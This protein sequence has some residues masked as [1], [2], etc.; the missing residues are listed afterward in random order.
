[1]IAAIYARKSTDQNLPDAEKPV[2]RQVDH[3]TAY[4]TRKGWTVAED[5]V[6]ADDAISG[7]LFGAQRPGLYRLLNA[8]KP[9]PP[10][11]V[12]VVMDQSRL[13][14]EQDEVPVACAGSRR[15]GSAS[16]ATS[17]T[18]RSSA[19]P[20]SRSFR[21]PRSRSWMRWPASKAGSAP[22]TRW[23]GRRVRGTSRAASCTG[24]RNVRGADHVDRQGAERGGRSG[25][26]RALVG[27]DLRARDVAPGPVPRAGH[28]R[29]NDVGVPRRRAGE[30]PRPAVGV[31][32]GGRPGLADCLRGAV[33]AG[34]GAPGPD[35]AGVSPGHRGKLWGRPETGL[36]SKYLL[37]G[38]AVC[39]VC[40]SSLHVR[41]R[42]HD[43]RS[44]DY[45]CGWHYSR[46]A[47]ACANAKAVPMDL[48]NAAVLTVLR[49]DVLTPEAVT[50]IVTQA[51]A[52]YR[53]TPDQVTQDRTTLTQELTKVTA[54]IARAD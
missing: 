25:A 30:A 20:P 3:A 39:G 32:H 24:I 37:T 22:R 8:L 1:M 31:D 48:A 21:L 10:F 18:R 26:T 7:A 11:Q 54:E 13:G 35:P 16:S 9:R 23:C 52:R 33:G 46:G 47:A 14:R 44:R 43:G 42:R 45:R 27:A 51:L 19:G 2:T 50:A 5:H 4:A 12:L 15:P 38:L 49:D 28:L 17:R 34:A 29:Q 41:Q 36:E 6:Y 40:G 53:E